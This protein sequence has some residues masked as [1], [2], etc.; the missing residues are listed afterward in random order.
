MLQNYLKIALRNLLRNKVYSFINILG[1]AIGIAS[2][3]LILLWVQNE[4]SID[5]HHSKSKKI[6]RI[7]TDLKINETET[8]HWAS[9]PLKFLDYFKKD[10]P[11]IQDATRMNVPYGD[12]AVKINQES[13]LEKSCAFV[14]KNWFELFDYQVVNG[15]LESFK[16]DK[17]GIILTES[18]AKKYF[19][20]VNPIGK[21]IQHDT[22]NFTVATIVK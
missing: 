13:F 18:K 1:L 11:E 19:G 5:Q 15:S 9:T 21:I 17:F 16:K 7:N 6:Y 3:V 10:V 22:L 8:W 2:T 4:V 20:N 14:D 12:F